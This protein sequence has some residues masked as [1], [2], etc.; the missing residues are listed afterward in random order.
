[1]TRIVYVNGRYLPQRAAT[2]HIE[3]RGYQFSDGVYEVEN[4]EGVMWSISEL[5]A[6]LKTQASGPESE[7]DLLYQKLVAMQ[8]QPTLPDDFSMLQIKLVE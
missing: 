5:E 3:D 2:V 7:M 8:G 4:A 1:M 6:F